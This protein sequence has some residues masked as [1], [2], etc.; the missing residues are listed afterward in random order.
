MGARP[1]SLD[2]RRF[3]IGFWIRTSLGEN[4][5]EERFADVSVVMPPSKHAGLDIH[6][7]YTSREGLPVSQG[8]SFV[9]G[10]LVKGIV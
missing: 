2:S 5:T 4:S 3:I 8:F 9:T 10:V 1:G 7:I 6:F